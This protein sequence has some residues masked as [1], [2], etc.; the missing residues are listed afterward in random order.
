MRV[1]R[2]N[3]QPSWIFASFSV[4]SGLGKN[5]KYWIAL[6]YNGSEW[7]W[8]DQVSFISPIDYFSRKIYNTIGSGLGMT[9]LR[10][11]TWKTFTFGRIAISFWTGLVKQTI[12]LQSTDP[13]NDW[14]VGQPYTDDGQLECAY[15][16][17]AM[18]LNVKW[19]V[20]GMDVSSIKSIFFALPVE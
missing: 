13:F 19:C 11:L 10:Y 20:S 8:D 9:F 17:Q 2:S 3:P 1:E 14:D 16:T 7:N 15:A 5:K 12:F 18:G 6:Q 4:V